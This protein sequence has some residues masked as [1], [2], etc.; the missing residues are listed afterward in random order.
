[1]KVDHDLLYAQLVAEI[2]QGEPILFSKD[3]EAEIERHNRLFYRESPLD[4]EFN[5]IYRLPKDD[6]KPETVWLSA[7]DIFDRLKCNAPKTLQG[8]TVHRMGKLLRRMGARKVHT[9]YG[10]RYAVMERETPPTV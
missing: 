6:E 8:I 2:E 10:N 5:K 1:M 9:M 4:D 7:G 3:E